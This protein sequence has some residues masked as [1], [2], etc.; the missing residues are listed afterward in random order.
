M[1]ETETEEKLSNQD[2]EKPQK[3]RKEEEVISIPNSKKKILKKKK[4]V[5][6]EK[7]KNKIVSYQILSEEK[8]K[9]MTEITENKDDPIKK[10]KISHSSE[11]NQNNK[12][13]GSKYSDKKKNK[14]KLSM[15]EFSEDYP[16]LKTEKERK[17][18][19]KKT[20]NILSILLIIINSIMY[21]LSLEG[22]S[23][24]SSLNTCIEKLNIIYFYNLF[25]QCFCSS[26]LSTIV[27]FFVIS[28]YSSIYNVLIVLIQIIC[29]YYI[30]HE[31]NLHSHGIVNFI[32]FIIS[33]CL[34]LL[35]STIIYFMIKYYKDQIIYMTYF[36]FFAFFYFW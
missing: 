25:I 9:T 36:F 31:N 10:N 35:I 28:K 23:K 18:F 13:Y 24:D 12:I 20:L 16:E 17:L 14:L 34:Q 6:Y 22:C 4:T 1:K 8:F 29:F 3:R 27:I 21:Y 30:D 11:A 5:K 26:F 2:S 7:E 32:F 19:I 33:L 15:T